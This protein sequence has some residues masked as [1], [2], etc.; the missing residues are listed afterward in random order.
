MY[1]GGVPPFGYKSEGGRLLPDPDRAEAVRLIFNTYAETGSVREA[2]RRIIQRGVT[3]VEGNAVS[4]GL[5]WHTLHKEV[6]TGKIIYRGKAYPGQHEALVSEDIFN[7]VQKLLK[8]GVRSPEKA[9]I[10]PFV[11]LIRCH[12][13]GSIMTTSY[14]EK[15]TEEGSRRYHYYR[16]GKLT[17]IGWDKCSIRQINA[18]RFH[19]ILYK[20]L[21][22]ISMDEEYLKN[23]VLAHKTGTPT[24]AGGGLEPG[25]NEGGL[26]PENLGKRL[27]EFLD[28]CARRTGM[29]RILAIRRHISGI[30]YSKK[31]I[32]VEFK[33]GRPSDALDSDSARPPDGKSLLNKRPTLAAPRAAPLES[34]SARTSESG[35][36]LSTRTTKKPGPLGGPDLNRQFVSDAKWWGLLGGPENRRCPRPEPANL[37]NFPEYST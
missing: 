36:C 18:E 3:S 22:R 2:R 26:T 6:Y 23:L 35:P 33:Y 11:G 31:T 7:H 13:C 21:L 5:V 10:L 32:S 15:K 34:T 29:E 14:T 28:F 1:I 24:A 12:E 37:G 19:D 27:K 17:H 16:C 30:N 20:N 25:Q 8:D 4:E 9:P